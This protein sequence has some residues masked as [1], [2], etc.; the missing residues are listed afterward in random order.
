MLNN[1]YIKNNIRK[2]ERAIDK[3]YNKIF[4]ILEI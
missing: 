3:Y 2:K 4:T 1:F